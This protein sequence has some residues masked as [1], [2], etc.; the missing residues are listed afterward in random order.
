MTQV[1]DIYGRNYQTECIGCSIVRGEIE[2]PGGSVLN[3]KHFDVHQDI[4]IPLPG[5]LILA[6]KRHIQSVDEFT[7]EEKREFMEVL[8]K[9]RKAMRDAM[10]I[11]TIYLVQEEDTSHH[12]H[13][14]TFPRYDWMAEKFGKKIESVRPIMR[15]CQENLKTEKII[16]EIEDSIRLLKDYFDKVSV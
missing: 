2:A 13:L 16:R 1:E 6:S 11:K 8:T 7:E 3:T 15:Y 9:T 14:W 10:G 4:C 12:F 5:F